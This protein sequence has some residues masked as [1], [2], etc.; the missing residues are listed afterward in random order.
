MYICRFQERHLEKPW[1]CSQQR[2]RPIR[3]ASWDSLPFTSWHGRTLNAKSVDKQGVLQCWFTFMISQNHLP[4]SE[5]KKMSGAFSFKKWR[6]PTFLCQKL[7]SFEASPCQ[8]V[9]LTLLQQA[10]P[11]LK[12]V[13]QW[14]CLDWCGKPAW[15]NV[16][17]STFKE[18]Y[19]IGLPQW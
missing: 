13:Q 11:S 2:A 9:L 16:V 12:A 17:K 6:W 19:L 18:V 4:A 15:S 8:P 3:K 10:W 5:R 7:S 14:T 1:C